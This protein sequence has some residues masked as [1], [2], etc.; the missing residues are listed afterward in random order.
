MKLVLVL[1]IVLCTFQTTIQ[2]NVIAQ[3]VRDLSTLSRLMNGIAIQTALARNPDKFYAIV[4]ELLDIGSEKTFRNILEFD[5]ND[6]SGKLDGLVTE[7]KK[8][9]QSVTKNISRIGEAFGVLGLA[10]VAE[11]ESAIKLNLKEQQDKWNKAAKLTSV[12]IGRN[13]DAVIKQLPIFN[14]TDRPSY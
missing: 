5:V 2:E 7:S 13:S 1:G 14:S 3:T 4:A 6:V 10:G 9:P 8:L 12:D 11:L